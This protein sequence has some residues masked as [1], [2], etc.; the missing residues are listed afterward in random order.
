MSLSERGGQVAK[1]VGDKSYTILPMAF[2]GHALYCRKCIR[3]ESLNG[4]ILP[5]RVR[6]N[7]DKTFAWMEVLGVGP[8]VGK[9]CSKI[10]QHSFRRARCL[11]ESIRVGDVILCPNR[12]PVGQGILA[13]VLE[14]E[15]GSKGVMFDQQEW[16]I[17]ESIPV[18]IYRKE[19]AA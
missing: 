16:F 9:P 10:H 3:A 15:G 14:G 5:D 6:E 8:K 12:S 11:N 13:S 19:L 1:N 2:A 17:E 4:I 18:V 7:V